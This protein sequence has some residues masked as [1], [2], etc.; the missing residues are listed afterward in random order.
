MADNAALLSLIA[1]TFGKSAV[2]SGAAVGV[3]LALIAPGEAPAYFSYGYANKADKV[4]FGS[5]VSFEIGSVTKVFTTN[6]L[7]QAIYGGRLALNQPISAF[8]RMLGSF[9]ALTAKVT[10]GELADFTAGFPSLAPI[11][12]DK[13]QPPGCLKTDR[14]P[15]SEYTAQDFLRYFQNAAPQN[16]QPPPPSVKALPAPYFYSDFT[17]GLLGLILGASPNAPLSNAALKGWE[18][19]LQKQILGPLNMRDTALYP[20]TS[21]SS[22]LGYQQAIGAPVLVNGALSA[23]NL[24]VAGAGYRSAADPPKVAIS[25]GAG[26][27]AQATAK[28][29]ANGSVTGFTV[30]QGGQ[31]YV[32]PPKVTFVPAPGFPPP[33]ASASGQAVVSGG[34]IIGVSIIEHGAG[35]AAAPTV[36]F[37]GGFG[38]GVGRNATGTVQIASGE[39]AYVGIADGGAGYAPPLSVVVDPGDGFTNVVPIWAPAGALHSTVQNMAIFAQAALGSPGVFVP[40]ALAAGFKI[41]QTP[42]ACTGPK[43]SLPKCPANIWLS[44]LAWATIPEDKINHVPAI[45]LKNGGLTGFSTEVM[46]MPARGLGVVVFANSNGNEVSDNKSTGEAPLIARGALYALFYELGGGGASPPR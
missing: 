24:V 36:V 46:L 25:G 43:P 9:K 18:G 33:A 15:T 38:G 6:L 4:L 31:G 12:N 44:D 21:S 39:V 32:A 13:N 40:P 28:V 5:D 14:P 29:G 42:R 45:V 22:A 3:G 20:P 27:G 10:L 23:I 17:V 41:A 30:V 16:F 11:C 26:V 34:K 35:Y 8:P 19:M 7:G 1:Q 2:D 37:S